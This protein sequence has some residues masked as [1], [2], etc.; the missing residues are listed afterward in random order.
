[1]SSSL[2]QVPGAAIVY[3]KTSFKFSTFV[4]NISADIL[5]DLIMSQWLYTTLVQQS[6]IA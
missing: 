5:P 2:A 1:M 4:W 6:F 3:I